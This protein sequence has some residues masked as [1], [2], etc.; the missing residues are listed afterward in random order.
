MTQKSSENNSINSI[1]K[2]SAKSVK[3]SSQKANL[4]LKLI[5]GQKV[6]KAMNILEF[7]RK[8]ISYDVLKVL[9]SAVSNAENNFQ[10]D[11][12]KLFVKEATVGRSMV[13]KRFRPRARGRSGKILKPFSKIRILVEEKNEPKPNQKKSSKKLSSEKV[14]TENEKPNKNQDNETKV[15]EK[16]DFQSNIKVDQKQD[17]TKNRDKDG[18]KN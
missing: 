2:A 17:I 16:T 14:I 18:T 1:A 15:Q 5:R 9:K 12:D 13:L 3:T 11:I 6:D 4:V 8:K 10:L 7:S